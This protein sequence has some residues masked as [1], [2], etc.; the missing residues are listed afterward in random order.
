MKKLS[1]LQ[2]IIVEYLCEGLNTAQVA[3]RLGIS[4]S[5]TQNIISTTLLKMNCKTRA[6]ITAKAVSLG[7]VTLHTLVD[8]KVKD[9]VS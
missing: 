6:E 9:I 3:D 1:P 7:I 2:K 8:S 5:T 4:V